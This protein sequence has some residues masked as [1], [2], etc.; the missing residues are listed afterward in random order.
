MRSGV[1]RGT[2]PCFAHLHCLLTTS[3]R[4]IVGTQFGSFVSFEAHQAVFFSI[5]GVKFLLFRH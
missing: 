2:G 1:P 5:A 3:V 4:S